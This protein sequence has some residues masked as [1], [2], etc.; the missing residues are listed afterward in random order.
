MDALEK[1][2]SIKTGLF[3]VVAGAACLAYFGWIYF[4]QAAAASWPTA[5]AQVVT[6]DVDQGMT[7]AGR[8]GVRDTFYA[9]IEYRY[10]VGSQD[11]TGSELWF[12]SEP[13]STDR[14]EMEKLTSEYHVGKKITIYYEPGNPRRAVVLP[15]KNT[16]LAKWAMIG[17]GLCL[18]IGGGMAYFALGDSPSSQQSTW[19]GSAPQP[20]T[21][22]TAAAEVDPLEARL[23]GKLS[24][25]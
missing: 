1:D 9:R 25:N 2:Q 12:D 10:S 15:G 17:G 20:A 5:T 16:A 14:S 7:L 24:G 11:Y 3:M 22:S 6:S 4:Q 13:M 8:R 21:A 19:G 18:L 23:L